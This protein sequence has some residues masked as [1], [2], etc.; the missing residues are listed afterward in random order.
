MLLRMIM[1][2][3]T[4]HDSAVCCYARQCCMLL[5]TTVLYAIMRDSAVFQYARQCWMPVG[6]TAA[7]VCVAAL[8]GTVHD[9]APVCFEITCEVIALARSFQTIMHVFTPFHHG[10]IDVEPNTI[11]SSRVGVRYR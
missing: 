1:L 10:L 5:R 9:K 3:A 2:Y 11:S 6:T 4:T 8:C 7:L